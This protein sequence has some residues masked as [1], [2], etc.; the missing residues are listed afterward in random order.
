MNIGLTE[1]QLDLRR[2]AAT[3]VDDAVTGE[4]SNSHITR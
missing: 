2:R 1:E 4:R 3:F